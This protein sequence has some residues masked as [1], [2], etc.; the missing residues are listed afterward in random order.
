M[1]D[2]VAGDIIDLFTNTFKNI[3]FSTI[4]PR[5]FIPVYSMCVRCPATE[6]TMPWGDCLGG[7]PIVEHYDLLGTEHELPS[8][9]CSVGRAM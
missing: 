9:K 3:D 5:E 2:T 1:V 8:E 4:G 7:H 6:I